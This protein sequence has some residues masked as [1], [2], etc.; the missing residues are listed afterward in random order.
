M[1]TKI[2]F[3][4]RKAFMTVAVCAACFSFSGCYENQSAAL[5]VGALKVSSYVKSY[6]SMTEQERASQF[7]DLVTQNADLRVGALRW[8]A[9]QDMVYIS[10][11]QENAMFADHTSFMWSIVSMAMAPG[12]IFKSIDSSNDPFLAALREYSAYIVPNFKDLNG[13]FVDQR[14]AALK[15]RFGTYYDVLKPRQLRD[16][17]WDDKLFQQVLTSNDAAF[18]QAYFGKLQGYDDAAVATSLSAADTTAL[19]NFFQPTNSPLGQPP[20]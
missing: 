1:K 14:I 7:N 6:S 19:I 4:L 16:L 5:E 12:G 3:V 20:S 9:Q 8:L 10:P 17:I 18:E 2:V 11:E 13:T 15:I